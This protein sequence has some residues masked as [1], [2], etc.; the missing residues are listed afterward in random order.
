MF[1]A[2]LCFAEPGAAGVSSLGGPPRRLG[3]N[4]FAPT[5]PC[6]IYPA[7][8]DW[9]GLTALTPAQWR[10]LCELIGRPELGG[11]PRFAATLMRL[12]AADEIDAILKPEFARHTAQYWVDEGIKRR[13]PITPVL[14]PGKLP[15]CPH[16]SGRGSFAPIAEK[17]SVYGPSLPFHMSFDGA[18]K[19]FKG[20]S[21]TAPLAGLRV[22]DFSMGWAG[23]LAGRMLADLG[24]DV[25]KIE[26]QSHPD[27][28]RSWEGRTSDDPGLLERARNFLDV[29]RGKKG[30][31][32]D[33]ATPDGIA[34]A[35][36][37]IRRGDVVIENLGPGVMS[38][39]GIGVADQQK[40]KPGIISIT[41]GAF[42]ASGG[43]LSVM[44][45]W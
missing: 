27:W 24:A 11:E 43:S 30:V 37:L 31:L 3:I 7:S 16:W 42:G 45:R 17:S 9:V 2:A 32:L 38:R 5:Y 25:V 8:D 6:S 40:L 10:S 26:S 12:R 15:E 44:G 28:W 22:V 14:A 1:E 39:L 34:A 4:R 41:M 18:A 13:I 35:K 33:L 21:K 23:P 36:D 20:G 19:P 29:N